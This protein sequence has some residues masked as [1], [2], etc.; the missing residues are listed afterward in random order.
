M[1]VQAFINNFNFPKSLGYLRE[2]LTSNNGL[3]NT[4]L[5]RNGGGVTWPAPKWTQ[6]GDICLFHYA[7]SANA[8]QRQT[9]KEYLLVEKTFG[10]SEQDLIEDG[11][12]RGKRDYE[13]WGGK[14]FA[15]SR[16]GSTPEDWGPTET[17]QFRTRT[18]VE[19]DDI[20]LLENPISAHEYSDYIKISRHSSITSVTGDHF[21]RLKELICKKNNVP[22]YFLEAESTPLEINHINSTNWFEL[23]YNHRRRFFL[24]EQFRSYYVDHLLKLLG[25]RRTFFREC[26]C[27]KTN[28]S[29]AVG[30]VDN[31]IST[32]TGYLPIEIKLSALAE[33]HLIKQLDKYCN[34]DRIK[35]THGREITSDIYRD[36]LL[37]I[38]LQSVYLYRAETKMLELI[39]S[40]DNLTSL[41]RV[42]ELR[43]KIYQAISDSG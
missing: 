29:R 16:V 15:I 1:N 38:D 10:H 26:D 21:D 43:K 14:T 9:Y 4:E 33:P 2:C 23:N 25:N 42:E 28:Y 39:E 7:I 5:F 22:R 13:R 32:P 12:R 24:E 6:L 31:V 18:W 36:R 40:L 30:K 3:L 8:I 34:V 27:F 35:V 11:F 19:F 37:V 17:D 41:A 20:C